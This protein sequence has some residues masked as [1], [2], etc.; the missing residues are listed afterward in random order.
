MADKVRKTA[1]SILNRLN[2]KKAILDRELEIALEKHNTFS[3]RDR[4]FLYQLVY[5]VI[6]WQKRLDWIIAGFSKTSMDKIDP[7]ILN[8]LRLGTYQILYL[9][10]TPVSAAVNTSV[11]LSKSISRPWVVKY[12]NGVLRQITRRHT[13]MNFPDKSQDPVL[14]LAITYAFPEWLIQ[15]WIDR[16]GIHKTELLCDRIN[17]IPPISIR[18]NTLKTTQDSLVASLDGLVENLRI[19]TYAPDGICFDLPKISISEIPAFQKGWFQVQDEAAQLV[20]VLLNPKPGETILDACAGLGGKTGHIAQLMHNTGRLYALDNS[21]Q[22]LSRL[23]LEMKRLGISIVTPYPHDLY[24]PLNARELC[25]FDRILL[26]APCSGLGVLRRNPDTKWN[27]Q[28]EDLQ[29]SQN[30]QIIFLNH[31]AP[32]VKPSGILNYTVCSIEPEE[33]DD[34]VSLFLKHHRHFSIEGSFLKPNN[35][36]GKMTYKNGYLRTYPDFRDM[37]G[38]FSVNFIR[39]E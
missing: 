10:K 30:R 35:E 20:T 27:V 24:T 18:T 15:R 13:D 9:D 8:I 25:L 7:Q 21:S 1:L 14:A 29:R 22:K 11:E 19:S 2:N 12:V 36:I 39:S 4:S 33:T 23:T 3:K 5:G 16:F 26:D 32:W 34:V 28:Q 38:F 37:D 31:L 6:R 17:T